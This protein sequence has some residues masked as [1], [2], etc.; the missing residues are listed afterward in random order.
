MKGNRKTFVI[1]LIVSII[2]LLFFVFD[3]FN[4]PTKLGFY[5]NAINYDLWGIL[6]GN[7][8]VI[9]LFIITYNLF[10]KRK[11]ERE[12]LADYA[13]AKLILDAYNQC[14]SMKDYIDVFIDTKA[15]NRGDYSQQFAHKIADSCF[16]N[17]E[18]VF[19]L[20]ASGHVSREHYEMY[21]KI[22]NTYDQLVLQLLS[23]KEFPDIEQRLYKELFEMLGN[24]QKIL[25]TYIDELKK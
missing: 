15:E 25:K 24:E 3:Y 9:A 20:L 19:E 5:V 1:T 17:S 21:L 6:V 14:E 10:D 4:I 23:I 11:L 8:V 22:K 18:R 7:G 13:S 2:V 12:K 16:N